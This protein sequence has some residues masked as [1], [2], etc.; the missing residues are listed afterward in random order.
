MELVDL[1]LKAY[2]ALSC[3]MFLGKSLML[4]E[5]QWPH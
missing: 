4:L 5:P 3:C 2:L 1:D